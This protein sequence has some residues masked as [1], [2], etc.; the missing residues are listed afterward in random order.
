MPYFIWED[1]LSVGV[2]DFDDEHKVLISYINKLHMALISGEA[3]ESVYGILDGLVEYTEKH[4]GH[5]EKLMESEDYP[6]LPGQIKEHEVFVDKIRGFKKQMEAGKI[7][8][9]LELMAFLRDWLMN[10][11]KVVDKAYSEF[12]SKKGII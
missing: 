7:N 11:I 9:S 6:G 5:E 12:F 4:F 2:K 1:N 10:H 3:A 8:F